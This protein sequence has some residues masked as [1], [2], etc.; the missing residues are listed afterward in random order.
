MNIFQEIKALFVVKDTV[1]EIERM[2]IKAGW[3]TTEFWAN[4]ATQ[5]VTLWGAVHGF[6]PPKWAAIVSTIGIAVYTV[7]RTVLKAVQDV[8]AAQSQ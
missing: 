4:A 1:K 8:K 3:K 7:A 6:I 5:I 2:D